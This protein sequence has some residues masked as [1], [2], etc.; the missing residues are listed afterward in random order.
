MFSYRLGLEDLSDFDTSSDSDDSAV[1]GPSN[2]SVAPSISS[3]H[4]EPQAGI[5]DSD[6]GVE[7]VTQVNH[8]LIIMEY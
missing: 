3:V 1:P 8:L 2:I 4:Q 6:S 5:A 7:S